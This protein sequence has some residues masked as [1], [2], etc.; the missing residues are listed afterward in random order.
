[1]TYYNQRF[2]L[3][4]PVLSKISSEKYK[5][6]CNCGELEEAGDINGLYATWLSHYGTSHQEFDPFTDAILKEDIKAKKDREEEDDAPVILFKEH[7]ISRERRE[8]PVDA[9]QIDGTLTN[10]LKKSDRPVD[11]SGDGQMMYNRTHPRGRKVN[12]KEQRT[13]H[14]ASFYR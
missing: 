3:H 8:V 5:L 1:M 2:I 12:S 7:I 6:I 13:K 11:A 14:G 10:M 4:K 9:T